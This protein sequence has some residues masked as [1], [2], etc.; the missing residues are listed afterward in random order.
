MNHDPGATNPDLVER[1]TRM[2]TKIDIFLTTHNDQLK[3]HEDRIRKVESEVTTSS[4]IT[5]WKAT[6]G[7]ALFL[8]AIPIAQDLFDVFTN[9]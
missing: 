5:K 4:A 7:L 8:A 9:R 3:D 2:E 1:M 6:V